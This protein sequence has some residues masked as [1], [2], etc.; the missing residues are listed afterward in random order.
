MINEQLQKKYMTYST[1]AIAMAHMKVVEMN[2]IRTSFEKKSGKRAFRFRQYI[3]AH[4]RVVTRAKAEKISIMTMVICP[5]YC[6]D[7][8]SDA[9]IHP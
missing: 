3:I 9:N 6:S 4:E 8:I 1:T 7:S 5:S 2:N